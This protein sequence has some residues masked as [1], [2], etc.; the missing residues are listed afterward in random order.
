V[1][2]YRYDVALVPDLIENLRPSIHG[3]VALDDSTGDGLISDEPARRR[4]LLSAA[5]SAGADWV[6]AI[7]PDERVEQALGERI[8]EFTSHPLTCWSF[9]LREMFT[10]GAWRDDGV[11]GRKKQMRLFPVLP[12]LPVDSLALHGRW[13]PVGLGLPERHTGLNLYHLRMAHP[14]RRQAR[15]DLYAVNDPD[16]LCQAIGYDY[17][18]DTRGMKLC[19]IPE[20]SG[21]KPPFYDDGEL[22]AAEPEGKPTAPDPLHCRFALSG[23]YIALRAFGPASYVLDDLLE[24]DPAD[25]DVALAAAYCAATAS[26]TDSSRAEYLLKQ[27]P[28]SAAALLILARCKAAASDRNAARDHVQ[29][30]MTVAPGSLILE[31]A[32]R[33]LDSSPAAFAE[34][35]ALWRRWIGK[36]GATLREGQRV[37]IGAEIATVVISLGAPKELRRAVASLC[38]QDTQTEIV[39][40]NTGGGDAQHVLGD[41]LERVRLI[42]VEERRFVGAARNIGID[43]SKAPIIAFLAAD[44]RAHQG[45]ISARLAHHRNG[46]QAVAS[47][48]IAESPV[49]SAARASNILQH[50]R[51]QP[52]TPASDALRFGLSYDRNLL[53]IVGYFSPGMRTGE[54]SNFNAR[55]AEI[56]NIDWAPEVLTT[57]RYPTTTIRFLRDC[58]K[59]GQL[60]AQHPPFIDPLRGVARTVDWKADAITRRTYRRQALR[61]AQDLGPIRRFAT[62]LLAEIGQWVWYTS[63]RSALRQLHSVATAVTAAKDGSAK[64]LELADAAVAKNPFS[65]AALV[66]AAEQRLKISDASSDML[67]EATDLLDRA[68]PLLPNYGLPLTLQGEARRRLSRAGDAADAAEFALICSPLA[69]WCALVAADAAAKAGEAGRARLLAQLALSLSIDTSNGH[70]RVARIHRQFGDIAGAKRRLRCAEMLEE[71][72]KRRKGRQQR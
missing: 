20:G 68:A 19:R 24:F 4:L 14:R 46:A 37:A 45:W 49:T 33:R 34:A 50:A 40:V 7:D 47:P 59:R 29:A 6:L 32:L 36:G 55:V 62:R 71:D 44:C 67:R 72:A 10:P 12:D 5:K 3:Y 23:K 61:R 38:D 42:E 31:Q 52:T 51:R 63:C 39:V 22:W 65:L 69:P 64:A 58:W 66:S 28:D 41:L 48:V 9:S 70:R 17:L 1:F 13:L 2:S 57:H 8:A 53:D 35:A 60:A 15:R 25:E 54:D 18:A 43:A 11:W 21:F 30:A 26:A 27:R 56:C 16:R